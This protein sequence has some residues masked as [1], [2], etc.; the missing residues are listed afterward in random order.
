MIPVCNVNTIRHSIEGYCS[1][2]GKVQELIN[3][4]HLVFEED[5]SNVKCGYHTGTTGQDADEYESFQCILQKLIKKEGPSM[6]GLTQR[7]GKEKSQ[8]SLGP[9]KI[10]YHKEKV[11]P[12]VDEIALF[13]GENAEK[14]AGVAITPTSTNKE[15]LG[16]KSKK[17]ASYEEAKIEDFGK[18]CYC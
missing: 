16:D 18:V 8:K 15:E 1:F 6:D 4:E 14:T 3:N 12:V 11:G 13:F 7:S 9:H 5:N 10:L 17:A 2:K